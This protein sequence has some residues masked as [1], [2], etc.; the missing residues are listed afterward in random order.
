MPHIMMKCCVS[1]SVASYRGWQHRAASNSSTVW[2]KG[3]PA[4]HPSFMPCQRSPTPQYVTPMLDGHLLVAGA[5]QQQQQ[6]H[7]LTAGAT[8]GGTLR[9]AGLTQG[10]LGPR[11]QQACAA[12]AAAAGS[13]NCLGGREDQAALHTTT[14]AAAAAEPASGKHTWVSQ[15]R[16]AVQGDSH[17]PTEA[18]RNSRQGWK[19]AVSANVHPAPGTGAA[20]PHLQRL[21]T[22]DSPGHQVTLAWCPLLSIQ[23]P[24]ACVTRLLLAAALAAARPHGLL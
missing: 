7:R 16:L 4:F 6:Q 18:P 21:P 24:V 10:L 11:S 22:G 14:A 5:K 20:W 23:R 9:A 1:M 12:S 3:A 19:P 8:Q 15:P 17:R 2:R 13:S